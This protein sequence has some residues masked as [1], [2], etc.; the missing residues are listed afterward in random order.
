MPTAP[1]PLW[2]Q[3]AAQQVDD[4]TIER[5]FADQAHLAIA[6]KAGPLMKDPYQLGFEVVWSN[7]AKS[8]LIG[9]FAF[10]IGDGLYYVPV[11]F[12]NGA[13]S[14]TDLLWNQTRK[15]FKPF[16]DEWVQHLISQ[17][18]SVRLGESSPRSRTFSVPHSFHMQRIAHPPSMGSG[19]ATKMAAAAQQDKW[20]QVMDAWCADRKTIEKILKKQ[21]NAG[22][23]KKFLEGAGENFVVKLANALETTP[24]IGSG[25]VRYELK[26]DIVP[27]A[28][29]I[30]KA[31]VDVVKIA[32]AADPDD[33]IYFA[34]NL[35]DL[36]GSRLSWWSNSRR[37]NRRDATLMKVSMTRKPSCST[38]G[39]RIARC[40]WSN[41]R[42]V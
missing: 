19:F 28:A 39:R 7:D 12:L 1:L 22:E 38:S 26:E 41:L 8:K 3:A 30:K 17:N 6:G 24:V 36:K 29:F 11:F 21:G 14:G 15:Q 4:G 31:D 42:S 32:T 23:L 9:I 18:Q 35:H 40:V 5:S 16:M 20:E 37:T 13:I 10:R 34:R 33:A 2:K 25:I 27:P